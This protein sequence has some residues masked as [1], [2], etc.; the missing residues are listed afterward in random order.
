MKDIYPAGILDKIYC[1]ENENGFI[2]LLV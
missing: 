1:L 2:C